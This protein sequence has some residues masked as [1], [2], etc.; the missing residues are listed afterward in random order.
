MSDC[1]LCASFPQTKDNQRE[2]GKES[3]RS[4]N[5]QGTNSVALLRRRHRAM[6]EREKKILSLELPP[7]IAGIGGRVGD[8]LISGSLARSLK[9]HTRTTVTSQL[10]RAL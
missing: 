6:S 10:A 8:D 4:E 2:R 3:R 5:S 9:P 7:T 1:S